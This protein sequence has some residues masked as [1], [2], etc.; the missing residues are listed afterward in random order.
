MINQL[1][2]ICKD[3]GYS[4]Y[5]VFSGTGLF[6]EVMFTADRC[7]IKNKGQMRSSVSKLNDLFSQIIDIIVPTKLA[8]H[9]F[10]N[11]ICLD[12]EIAPLRC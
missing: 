1:M 2:K 12:L 5:D 4:N 8:E 7:S 10:L 9:K 6:D 11:E 3:V